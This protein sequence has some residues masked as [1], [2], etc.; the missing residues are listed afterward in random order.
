MERPGNCGATPGLHISEISEEEEEET[1]LVVE[2]TEKDWDTN[3]ILPPQR[4]SD[5]EKGYKSS[6]NDEP[7]DK[8]VYYSDKDDLEIKFKIGKA[9]LTVLGPS[10]NLT[11]FEHYHNMVKT[12]PMEDRFSTLLQNHTNS[13]THILKEL[14]LKLRQWTNEWNN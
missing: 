6:P 1:N 8:F 10:Q 13:F 2:D 9:L 11:G 3:T 12:F 5:P 7:D 14:R 4:K